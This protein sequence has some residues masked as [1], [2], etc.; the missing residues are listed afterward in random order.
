MKK[1]IIVL[2]I[3][4][5]FFGI[6][7]V[8][9]SDPLPNNTWSPAGNAGVGTGINPQSNF[10]IHGTANYSLTP[11]KT[12]PNG[13]LPPVYVSDFGVSSKLLFTNTPT[14]K[15]ITD[16]TM[17][18]QSVNDFYIDNQ[19]AGGKIVLSSTG[20]L[21]LNAGGTSLVCQ[22]GTNRIFTGA[23]IFSL[24]NEYAGF[25]IWG[26]SSNGLNVKTSHG[27]GISVQS[28]NGYTAL[29]I[30]GNTETDKIFSVSAQDGTFAKKLTIGAVSSAPFSG[31]MNLTYTVDATSSQ[32]LFQIENTEDKLVQI[33]NQG[34]LKARR[35]IVNQETWSDYVFEK[36]YNLLPLNEV[37]RYI[38]EEKHLPG[39]PSEEEVKEE[40]V[41]V[42]KMDE[43][44]LKKI[45]EM[46]L[47]IIEMNKKLEEQAKEIE[48]LKKGQQ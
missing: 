33:D 2:A 6:S 14:G 8:N 44:L 15:T 7:Q 17:F 3:S 36:E 40:G 39:V 46:T 25:N 11:P 4:A 41:D 30:F 20:N 10:H 34:L 31:L 35:I 24:N 43:I 47:Y 28:T 22:G 18:H 27:H 9:T 37:E 21:S 16:G 38:E 1:I 23:Q 19:E 26:A 12:V 29:R 45:E 5:P 32:T 42:G 48:K 13:E